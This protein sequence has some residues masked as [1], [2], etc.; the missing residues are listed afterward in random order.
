MSSKNF[1]VVEHEPHS[2]TFLVGLGIPA[3]RVKRLTDLLDSR[4]VDETTVTATMERVSRECLNVN[5][6]FWVGFVIGQR[7]VHGWP[8]SKIKAEQP[9]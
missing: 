6:L 1:T 3:Q 4:P 8:P 2:K 7:A 5:E 9:V